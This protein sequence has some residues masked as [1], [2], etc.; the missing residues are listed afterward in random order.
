[1][2]GAPPTSYPYPGGRS[3]PSTSL[4]HTSSRA[5]RGDPSYHNYSR[6]FDLIVNP[7]LGTTRKVKIR[8]WSN[9]KGAAA[10][11]AALRRRGYSVELTSD[12]YAVI[13]K[14]KTTRGVERDKFGRRILQYQTAR[15]SHTRTPKIPGRVKPYGP[16]HATFRQ[17]SYTLRKMG[18]GR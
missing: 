8:I 10:D 2:T 12:K 11:A 5:V 15:Q 14:G 9:K 16:A 3:E 17:P 13:I 4:M 1:M 6:Q 18:Y 7:R